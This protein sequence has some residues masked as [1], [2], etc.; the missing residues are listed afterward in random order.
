MA[1]HWQHIKT[2]NG[3][4][5]NQ[6]T[7][8]TFIEGQM[9]PTGSTTVLLDKTYLPH[10]A[11]SR[12]NYNQG[13]LGP[14]GYTGPTGMVDCG[15]IVTSNVA[16]TLDKSLTLKGPLN[17]DA[18]INLSATGS[19]SVCINVGPTGTSQY[20]YIRRISNKLYMSG[21]DGI[22]LQRGNNQI[23]TIGYPGPT[24]NT[25][26]NDVWFGPTGSSVTGYSNVH[27]A[28]AIYANSKC[29]AQFFNATSDIRA[30]DNLILLPKNM[31]D[32]VNKVSVYTFNYKNNPSLRLPGLIAQDLVDYDI[33]GAKLVDNLD[34][35]GENSFMSIHESKLIYVLWGAVQEL[36]EEV[37]ELKKQ[38]G[39]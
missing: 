39:K 13:V 17:A 5:N 2:F 15:Y 7:L 14:S 12:E 29:E 22:V 31:L 4:D 26:S 34:A 24:G 16:N 18:D 21:A 6:R 28:G 25:Y 10:I 27:V 32:L 1:L 3:I 8:Y 20:G 35:D 36:S 38:L 33:D 19:Y 9:G 30:K 11:L 37:K 23:M